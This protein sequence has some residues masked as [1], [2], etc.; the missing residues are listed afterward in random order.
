MKDHADQLIGESH[1]RVVVVIGLMLKAILSL[2][3]KNDQ[4]LTL[5]D[6]RGGERHDGPQMFLTSVLKRLGG[7]S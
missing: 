1:F 3:I 5:F 4:L 2:R 7:G 6:M